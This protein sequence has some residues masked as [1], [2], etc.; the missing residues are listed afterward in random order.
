MIQKRLAFEL[1]QDRAPVFQMKNDLAGKFIADHAMKF[2][3]F[4]A[5]AA[6][7]RLDNIKKILDLY[8]ETHHETLIGKGVISGAPVQKYPAG[9]FHRQSASRKLKEACYMGPAASNK[10]GI[11]RHAI[12][13]RAFDD[14]TTHETE[15]SLRV[16]RP[17]EIV[18]AL[19]SV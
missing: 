17:L 2:A 4:F 13:R 7:E 19:L 6:K 15:E 12:P 9:I 16:H 8:L 5:I 10:V 14:E 11:Q 18:D 1:R 3:G